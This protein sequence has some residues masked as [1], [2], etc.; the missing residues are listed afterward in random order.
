M[1]PLK[2]LEQWFVE[3]PLPDDHKH[4]ARQKAGEYLKEKGCTVFR[5]EKYYEIQSDGLRARITGYVVE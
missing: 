5:E 1:K 4:T 3:Y 2:V